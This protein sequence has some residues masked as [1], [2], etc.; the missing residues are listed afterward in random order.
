MK[1]TVI[2]VQ[3]ITRLH[4]TLEHLVRLFGSHLYMVTRDRAALFKLL[5]VIIHLRGLHAN[6]LEVFI[7]EGVLR[8]A[9]LCRLL[10]RLRSHITDINGVHH[11]YLPPII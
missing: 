11:Y 7:S 10:C 8:F 9:R 1:E 2:T 3:F 6:C 4:V 5:Y